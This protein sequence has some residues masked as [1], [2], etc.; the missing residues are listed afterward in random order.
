MSFVKSLGHASL[1]AIF[2]I[3]GWG[4]FS[5]PGG[6]VDMVANAGI[7]RA[8][9]ATILNATTM[10]VAGTTLAAGI[11]PRIS[12]ALLIG[13]LIPTTYVGHAFWKEETPAGRTGQQTQ[14]LKNLA[15]IGGLLLVLQE[16]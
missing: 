1:G 10:I 14:F 13:S 6:R 7:P 3:N 11:F 16:G 4:A 2:V 8:R 5:N 15:M 9:E 12:A